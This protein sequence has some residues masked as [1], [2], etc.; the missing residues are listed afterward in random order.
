MLLPDQVLHVGEEL[1]VSGDGE[2]GGEGAAVGGRHD[3][4]EHPPAAQQHTTRPRPQTHHGRLP[5]NS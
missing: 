2:E 4:G 5:M 3:Q 1:C